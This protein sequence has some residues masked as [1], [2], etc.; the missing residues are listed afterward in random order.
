MKIDLLPFLKWAFG[1]ELAP[2]QRSHGGGGSSSAWGA[3]EMIARLGCFIDGT[4]TPLDQMASTIVHPDAAAAADAVMLLSSERFDVPDGWK[5]FP[6]LF[7]PHGAI[8]LAVREVM[9]RR[10]GT[11]EADR[12]AHLIA[13]VISYAVMEREP[14]WRVAQP[15]FRM[16]DRAGKPAWFRTE[17]YTDAF[18]REHVHEVD[19]FNAKAG[20]PYR[21]AYRKYR[22]KE[23][24][25]GAVQ[26]RIDWY[27]WA[28]ALERIHERL[29]GRLKSHVIRPFR[30]MREP[31]LASSGEEAIELVE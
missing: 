5:P 3:I 20:R 6:E 23:P 13:L 24:F 26:A 7:D 12:N 30:V 2:A 16:V 22:T 8:A 25:G 10:A 19:G 28:M 18:G 21:G 27:L 15:K 29:D 14:E 1:E 4:P 17:R 31:W 11:A 9:Q